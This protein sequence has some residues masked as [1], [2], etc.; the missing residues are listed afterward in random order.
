MTTREAAKIELAVIMAGNV[1][2]TFRTAQPFDKDEWLKRAE[3]VV[4]VIER[5]G[6]VEWPAWEG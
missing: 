4:A 3:H 5:H 2:I 1:G 6:R